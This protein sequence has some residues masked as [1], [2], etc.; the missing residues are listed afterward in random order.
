ME[1]S[2]IKSMSRG[3]WIVVGFIVALLVVPSVA[4]AATLR[5]TG[6]E[7]TNGTT[8]TV[9]KAHVTSAGEVATA[10]AD[11]DSLYSSPLQTVFGSTAVLVAQPPSGS[12]LILTSLAVTVYSN[13]SPGIGNGF[14]FDI[15]SNNSCS[16]SLVGSFEA[17]V[18]ISGLNVVN[19]PIGSGVAIPAG[20]ALCG[21][22]I[23]SP[24]AN[25]WANGY[26]VPSGSVA[27]GVRHAP[28]VPSL[29][30]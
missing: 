2:K 19:V 3:G 30:G 12:A 28:V 14:V 26:V 5:F 7:G 29:R 16:G 1:M 25:V 27:A 22:A 15:N 9:N 24:E 8:S 20:D 6:I 10:P 13:P 23:G 21:E 18:D 17:V 4:V 11:P